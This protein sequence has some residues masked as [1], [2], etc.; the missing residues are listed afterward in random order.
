MRITKKIGSLLEEIIS[1]PTSA[2]YILDKDGTKVVVRPGGDYSGVDLTGLNLKGL[3]LQGTNFQ[4]ANLSG[5]DFSGAH[6]EGSDLTKATLVG[7]VLSGAHLD[8]ASF[9][10]DGLTYAVLDSAPSGISAELITKIK[11]G[12]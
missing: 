9:D 11:T 4:G 8:G 12:V 5:V 1:H 10:T 7:T 6:L 3:N 2:S